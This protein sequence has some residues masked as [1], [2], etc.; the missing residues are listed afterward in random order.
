[1]MMK[2]VRQTNNDAYENGNITW[3]P[4]IGTSTPILWRDTLHN[5]RPIFTWSIR[6]EIVSYNTCGLHQWGVLINHLPTQVS[7]YLIFTVIW[8]V[9]VYRS[10]PVNCKGGTIEMTDR[11]KV[12]LC[13]FNVV[14]RV[15]ESTDCGIIFTIFFPRAHRLLRS[16][17]WQAFS[18]CVILVLQCRQSIWV[19]GC[20][21][22]KKEIDFQ[23][24]YMK[25]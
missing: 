4:F 5:L 3:D 24:S 19:H 20:C 18:S 21:F 6:Y 7:I 10:L 2:F 12:T 11:K 9:P 17:G 25:I 23:F 15:L 1:M 14:H 13:L 8:N 16:K 22:R